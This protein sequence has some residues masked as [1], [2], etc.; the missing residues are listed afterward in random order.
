MCG[1][2]PHAG[3]ID[4]VGRKI[5]TREAWSIDFVRWEAIIKICPLHERNRWCGCTRSQAVRESHGL[6]Q[7]ARTQKGI[8]A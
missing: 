8:V 3:L 2:S 7:V 5:E 4:I 6:L 1:L